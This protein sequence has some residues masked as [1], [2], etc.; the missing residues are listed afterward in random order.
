MSAKKPASPLKNLPDPKRPKTPIETR[1]ASAINIE[2]VTR[3]YFSVTMKPIKEFNQ[4]MLP[5]NANILERIFYVNDFENPKNTRSIKEI[6]DQILPEIVA[7]YAKVPVDMQRLDNCKR[8]IDKVYKKWTLMSNTKSVA[9]NTA[10]VIASYEQELKALCDLTAKNAIKNISTD[11]MRDKKQKR[12]DIAY[13]ENQKSKHT[14]RMSPTEDKSFS[15][16]HDRKIKRESKTQSQNSSINL[17]PQKNLFD[18]SPEKNCP[19]F[20]SGWAN[21]DPD[22]S[23]QTSRPTRRTLDLSSNPHLLSTIDR[24]GVSSRK[25]TMISSATAMAL[26]HSLDNI[27]LSKSAV[28]ENRSKN[29]PTIAKKVKDSFQPPKR[30][31][32]HFDGKIL[33]DLS[34]NCGDHLAVVLSGDTPQCRQGKLLSARMIE[35]G[36]GFDQ[37]EEV[38]NSIK[39]W[40]VVDCITAA[41][42]DTTA[43]NTGWQHGAAVEIEKLLN[44]P[45]LWLPGRH[46]IS[47]L[48]LGAAWIAIFGEPDKSPYIQKYKDF[49]KNWGNIDKSNYQPLKIPSSMEGKAKEIIMFCQNTLCSEKLT[50]NDYKECL[51]LTLI[52]LGSEPQKFTFKKPGN[53]NKTR[54]MAHILYGIKIFLFRSQVLKR[55]KAE[56]LKFERFVIFICMFYTKH[57]FL[58]PIASDAPS[59]DLMLYKD[60]LNYSYDPQVS[61]AILKKLKK[62]TWYMNQEFA[63]L[64]LFSNRVD[65]KVKVEIARK[66]LTVKPKKNLKDYGMG[67]PTTVPL[68]ENKLRG[69]ELCVSDFVGHG[70][71]F[72]FQTMG[73][74]HNWLRK[75]I[76][77]W[78]NDSS[79]LEMEQYVKT[80]LVVND[81]A[82]RGIKL[83]SDYINILT[84]NS[85]ERED[86]L[87]VVEQH[88]QQYPDCNRSTLSKQSFV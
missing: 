64:N 81:S 9:Y 69:L 20:R 1:G 37:A 26:G 73:F 48:F 76:H 17:A 29:R 80:L 57:W 63:P 2:S 62:H 47:E 59:T 58:A 49:Q 4:L 55:A 6:I 36:S 51:E 7:I 84:K 15:Q 70:S 12:E 40:K 56:Q 30:S 41:C 79:Y 88:R 50:R 10:S 38:L 34:Q 25:A 46:H 18:E 78:K 5:T 82:E 32:I 14:F 65:E 31:T 83:V 22:C 21:N 19:T 68:P 61:D 52:A 3:K 85:E 28:H 16:R 45:I 39:E 24:V 11:S 67:Q 74:N 66:L 72:I 75:P 54:W 8:K 87:Q 86:L 71:L 27:K 35:T 60:M 77:L 23:L 33:T 53:F 43:A 44:R 42:F 13:V